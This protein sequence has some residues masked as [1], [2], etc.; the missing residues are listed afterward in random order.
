MLEDLGGN[1]FQEKDI[2]QASSHVHNAIRIDAET[3]IVHIGRKSH[4]ECDVIT[5]IGN[6]N[7][8]ALLDSGAGSCVISFECYN[9]HHHKY[10]T[11]LFPSKIWIKAA[12][13]TSITNKG[14][15]DITLRIN[16]DQFTFPF[17]CSDQLSQ[18]MIIG[19]NFSKAYHISMHWNEDDMMSLT[20]NGKPFAEACSQ[21]MSMPQCSVL[22]LL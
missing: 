12:I 4:D 1:D 16:D 8:K 9:S 15:C 20:R 13:G 10:K 11:E 3:E 17:L 18:Q 22:N 7:Q 5:T 2:R 14:K 19:H 6:T 21:M